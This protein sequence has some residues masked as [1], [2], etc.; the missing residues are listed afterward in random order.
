MFTRIMMALAAVLIF[1]TATAAIA[2][3]NAKAYTAYASAAAP[4]APAIL[5]S[6]NW[7]VGHDTSGVGIFRGQLTPTCLLSLKQQSRC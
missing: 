1:G 4:G 6:R 7:V 2:R 5:Y 3:T